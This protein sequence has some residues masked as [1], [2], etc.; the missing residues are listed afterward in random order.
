MKRQF[1][2]TRFIYVIILGVILI[3]VAGFAALFLQKHNTAITCRDC[4]II[5]IAIDPMRADSLLSMGGARDITPNIDSL[6]E[7]G[8][9]F[10]NTIAASSWTLPSAMSFMTGVYPARHGI[11]NK[12][13]LGASDQEKIIPA[14]RKETA[15]SVAPLVSVFQDHGYVTGGFAGGAALAP[16]YGFS[17]GFDVYESPGDFNDIASS[18]A[19]ALDF[20]R[21]HK[22][23]KFFVFLHGFDVHGQYK[24]QEGFSRKYVSSQYTGSLTG[25]PVE[26][27]ELREQGVRQGSVYMTPED[28]M[29]LRS[30][31]DEKVSALDARVGDFF[32]AYNA[33]D[34]KR[35]TIIVFTS[36]HGDEFYEHG[37]IDHGMTLYDE[38]IRVPYIL[39]IPDAPQGK[40]I[41]HQVRN[42][43]ILPTLIDLVGL[44]L[45]ADKTEPIEGVSLMPLLQG[46]TMKLDAISETAYRYATF[47]TAIR[48]WDGWKVIY[49]RELQIKEVYHAAKDASEVNNRYGQ[50]EPKEKE[51]INT[52]LQYINGSE[53]MRI[54]RQI[55]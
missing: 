33:M 40:K 17:D 22:D 3:C 8:F 47:Q 13:L 24:P 18:S 27:K 11:I 19:S 16:S 20:I 45:P 36:H 32:S 6:S 50:N 28:A 25:D 12:E 31:Y 53:R 9:A 46:K 5:V 49:D 35:K 48:S 10:T 1:I 54:Q 38:V 51:L 4:N 41:N 37:R 44:P 2:T 29:F 42:I 21:Q 39:V 55:K 23:Q 30:I 7:K 15:P 34:I 26:Q 14:V 52:L 43:D